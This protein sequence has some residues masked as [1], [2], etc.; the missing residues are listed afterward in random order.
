MKKKKM[1]NKRRSKEAGQI[2]QIIRRKMIQKD[3]G[4]GKIY[5]RKDKK[6]LKEN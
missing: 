4:D 1:K 5:S 3:H 2:A 6:W